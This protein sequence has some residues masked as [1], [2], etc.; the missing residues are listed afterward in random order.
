[1]KFFHLSD[2]HIGKHLYYYSLLEDQRYVLNQV[3]EAAKREKPDAILLSGDIY[4]KQLPSAEAVRLLDWFLTELSYIS[5]RITVLV[6][7][8]NHDSGERLEFAKELLGQNGVHIAGLPCRDGQEP[9]KR[10]TLEDACGKVHFYLLP[11]TK[12]A[13]VRSFLKEKKK[14]EKIDSY[15]EA[16]ETLLRRIPLNPKERNVLLSHQFYVAGSQN[17]ETC[18]SEIRMVGGVDQVDVRVLEGFDYAALGHI[19]R[20][21]K[22]GRKI[23][24]YAGTLLK[25]SVSEAAHQKS[26]TMVT[27]GEKGEEPEIQQIPVEP[28]R[29]LKV[30]RGTL[31]E[32]LER[33]DAAH[34][35]VSITL[36]DEEEPYLPKERLEL[37]FDHILEIRIDNAR[38]RKILDFYEEEEEEEDLFASFGTFFE[39]TQGRK[40]SEAE[41][42]AVT[43]VWNEIQEGGGV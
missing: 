38:T 26:F 33:E 15:E 5:P 2:L 32:L 10:V 9:V 12:P 23:Y 35:F 37:V 4:D 25:Y 30:L 13:Y 20:A 24:R 6:I 3:L 19:H 28:L 11:F 7:G 17:P 42:E 41:L 39:L 34:D 18:D 31:Q 27:L 36:T 8:G 14:E 43:K 21:Q 1:M 40:M 29:D 16:V 22:I